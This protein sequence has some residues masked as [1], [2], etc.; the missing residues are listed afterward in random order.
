MVTRNL[1]AGTTTACYYGTLHVQATTLLADVCR[2]A[3]QRALVGRC[4]MDRLSPESY[5][6]AGAAA[7]M[8]ST[9]AYLASFEGKGELV[10]PV[11]TPRFALSC[12]DELLSALGDLARKLDLPVQTHIAENHDEIR[13]I[14]RLFPLSST[15]AGVY[16]DHGLLGPRTI[17]AHGVHL[18]DAE[19]FVIARAGAGISHCP[20][21]NTNLNSGAARVV[22][23]LG[24][25]IKVGLGSDC[26]GGPALGVLAAVR[27]AQAVSRVLAFE[28]LAPRGLSIPELFHMATR[29]GAQLCC[30]DDV[31]TL[32]P[33]MQFDALWVRPRSPGMWA[34]CGDDTATLFEKW[35]FAGDDRDIAA[36]WV[37]GQRVAGTSGPGG[38]E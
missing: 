28:K 21:S 29:G 18:N 22:E 5:V 30:L 16:R 9:A 6:E 27:A 13:A 2:E 26:S 36:V 3:G 19:R 14:H 33:G 24:E 10:R 25:G 31:G 34:Q 38:A 15:Y 8:E 17:L 37:A 20:A 11:L 23:L 4:S 7:S 35:L 32:A 12:S 1:A